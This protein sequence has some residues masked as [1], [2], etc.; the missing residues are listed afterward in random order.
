MLLDLIRVKFLTCLR[1]I[2]ACLG[3]ASNVILI[4]VITQA[5]S[6]VARA[7]SVQQTLGTFGMLGTWANNCAQPASDKNFITVFSVSGS[8]QVIRTQYDK[9]GSKRNEYTITSAKRL[10][11]DQLWYLQVR[12]GS[13]TPDSQ[14]EIT[15]KKD[16][17][18]FRYLSS[19]ISGSSA[20]II[21][22]GKFVSGGAET[23]W[24]FKCR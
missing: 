19:K 11:D 13:P 24:N 1:T 3:H 20:F 16:G 22:D 17:D 23:D 14:V 7:Q 4:V 6:G 5:T 15:L 18:K 2:A 12:I 10:A 21:K 8:G 9:P